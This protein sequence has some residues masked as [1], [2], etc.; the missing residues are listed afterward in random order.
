MAVVRPWSPVAAGRGIGFATFPP[1]P[2]L[3]GESITHPVSTPTQEPGCSDEFT[4]F[5]RTHQD[6]VFTTAARLLGDD[7]QAED[8]AQDVFVKAF[9]QFTRL[10]GSPTAGGWLRTVARHEAL[11]HLTRHRRRWRLFS[12]LGAGREESGSPASAELPSIP[13]AALSAPEL[14]QAPGALG[15]AGLTQADTALAELDTEQRRI[16]IEEALQRLPQAQRVPLVLYHFEELSYEEI[17]SQLHASLSKI[18][19]DIHR[20]RT[21][22]LAALRS[23]GV[24]H[25]L[26]LGLS[27]DSLAGSTGA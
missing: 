23:R 19:T 7:A 9:Q 2:V 10:R 25:E 14:P 26:A 8:V 21:A 15:E 17:A 18:K 12:E 20:G 11:N 4:T 6:M 3:T 1:R 22:L 24:A 16:L 13:Q 27:V 5:M